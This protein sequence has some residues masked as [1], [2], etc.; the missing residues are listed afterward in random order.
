MC[1]EYLNHLVESG[2]LPGGVLHVSKQRETVFFEAYGTFSDKHHTKHPIYQD[3]IF[4]VASLTKIMVTL[5]S[6]LFLTGRRELKLDTTVHSIIPEFP[7]KELTI[8]QLLQHTSGLPADLL[9]Q[10][11]MQTRDVWNDIL[12]TRLVNKPGEKT[13]YSDVGMITLGKVIE[14]I[15][16]MPLHEFAAQTILEPWGLHH[17]RYLLPEDQKALA[18]STEW[19][20][21]QFI[22]GEVHDEKAFQLGGVSGSAGLFSTAHDVATFSHYWLYPEKQNVIAPDDMR[23]ATQH[24][25]HNRGLGFEVWSGAGDLLSCGDKWSIGSFG[26]TGFTGTSLWIDPVHELSVVFLT[27]AVHFGRD[28]RIREIRK[29]LHSLIYSSFIE[30]LNI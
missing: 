21:D 3:T 15:A 2:E 27:N 4:D 8:N 9:F 12:H 18:A 20:K 13:L 14:K 19:Y 7:H 29:H 25:Q 5:P 24:R 11:R 30:E 22:Q 1:K 6:V 16:G 10:D 28:T 26:H 23:S 17:T